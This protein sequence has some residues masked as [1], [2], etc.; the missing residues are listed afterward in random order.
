MRDNSVS[1]NSLRCSRLAVRSPAAHRKRLHASAEKPRSTAEQPREAARQQSGAD[2]Q[3]HRQG[4]FGDDQ[5]AAHSL[6]FRIAGGAAAFLADAR[7]TSASEVACHAGMVPNSTAAASRSPNANP[8]TVHVETRLIEQR[9]ADRRIERRDGR[10]RPVREHE[11]PGAAGEAE[12]E[13]FDQQPA[14]QAGASR[15]DRDAHG[16][17]AAAARPANQ[18]ET[19]HVHADDQQH[20]ARRRRAARTSTAATLPTSDSRSGWT[21]TELSRLVRR[22]SPWPAGC[23]W[24]ASQRAPPRSARRASAGRARRCSARHVAFRD[25]WRRT[26]TGSTIRIAAGIR[27]RRASRRSPHA[28]RRRPEWC[29]PTICGFD[30]KRRAQNA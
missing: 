7:T 10:G 25:P 17:L 23:R 22:K 18:H 2:Q 5:Q 30:P 29:W 21:D 13:A 1:M 14:H 19:G 9:H 3:H 20:E 12:H 27:R 24:C 4:G 28:R 11:S 16:H 26:A 6:P 8:T 15:A